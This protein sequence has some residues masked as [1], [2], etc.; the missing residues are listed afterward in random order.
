MPNTKGFDRAQTKLIENVED[1]K[2][3][4]LDKVESD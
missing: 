3:K 2:K 4:L 1:E